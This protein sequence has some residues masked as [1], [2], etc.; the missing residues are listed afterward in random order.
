M[1]Q[2]QKG[3]TFSGSP[4]NDYAD[5]T[6]LNNLVDD[7]ILLPGAVTE[8]TQLT[9]VATDDQVI[10]HDES[11]TAL[12]RVTVANLTPN[13]SLALAKLETDFIA[14]A[15]AKAT[16]VTAD[17]VLIGD[18]A[19]A[20]VTKKS[21]LAQVA[22]AIVDTVADAM[23]ATDFI[24]SATVKA[25]PVAAD[26]VLIGD[27]AASNVAK[28]ATLT[29]LAP[30][31]AA[32]LGAASTV[33]YTSSQQVLPSAGGNVSLAHGLS[34]LPRG[35]R[36][37]LVCTTDDLGYS[38]AAAVEVDVSAA[39]NNASQRPAF[40]TKTDATN[41]VLIR[42]KSNANENIMLPHATTG[43]F[44]DITTTSWRL[45]VYASI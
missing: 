38:S 20:N 32:A 45:K 7:A 31:L 1:G 16:P 35:V 25:S 34:S 11:A 14:D 40:V 8:Q 4:P 15:T 2:I 22:A 39:S 6:R 10:V 33:S 37:V 29:Q 9:D 36:W 17:L 3:F 44:T 13:A 18:S 27:S 30:A 43:V 41:L 26:L 19:A 23:V 21:T 42:M 5:E 24:A 12:K 28:K